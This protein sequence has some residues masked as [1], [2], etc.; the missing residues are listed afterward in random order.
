MHDDQKLLRAAHARWMLLCEREPT[1]NTVDA[2][3]NTEA[4]GIFMSSEPCT[5]GSAE[6]ADLLVADAAAAAQHARVWR[7]EVGDC[8]VQVSRLPWP[9]WLVVAVMPVEQ[10]LL[11]A[12]VYC[13]ALLGAAE[14]A[15][16]GCSCAGAPPGM[17]VA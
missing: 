2:T 4:K 10:C 12:I 8:W 1:C 13:V 3:S 16:G 15:R 5:I 11:L 17:A 14:H 9:W 7:D 6:G